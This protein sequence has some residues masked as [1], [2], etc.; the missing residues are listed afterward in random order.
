MTSHIQ[1]TAKQPATAVFQASVGKSA[2]PAKRP[3]PIAF[4]VSAEER[5]ELVERAQGQS[6]N[7]YVR[8]LVF[9]QKAKRYRSA[10]TIDH[11]ILAQVL[12]TIGQLDLARR[13]KVLSEAAAVGA[14]PVSDETEEQLRAACAAV[15]AVKAELMRGLGYKDI[16]T[17]DP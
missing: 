14:L 13:L 12:G 1:N 4:R 2:K 6:L 16:E 8:Q 5:A 15:I 3:A 10:P 7:A 17:D 11:A 9:G